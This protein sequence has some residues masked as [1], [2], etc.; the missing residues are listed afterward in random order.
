MLGGMKVLDRLRRR[1]RAAGIEVRVLDPETVD[2]P[3]PII[4]GDG[5]AP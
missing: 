1:Y 3:A 2:P 5:G 4:L